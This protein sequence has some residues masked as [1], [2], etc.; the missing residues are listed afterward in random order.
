VWRHKRAA[1]HDATHAYA[2]YSMGRRTLAE[3]SHQTGL[4]LRTWQRRFDAYTPPVPVIEVSAEPVALTF[5]AT[6]FGRGYGVLIFRALGKNIHWQEIANERMADIEAGLLHLKR[7]GWLFSSITLDGRKGAISLLE[8]HFP[9]VP[10]QMCLFHQKAI[11]RRYLTNTPKTKCAKELQALMSFFLHIPEKLFLECLADLQM[12]YA[13]FLKE[14][15]DK[16]Q[17]MHRRL[18]SALRSLRTNAPYLFAYQRFPELAIPATTNSCDGS[19]AH[20]K[21]KIK[22]HRGMRHHRRAKMIRFLLSKT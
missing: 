19:F 11:I 7:Q 3:I 16:K 8:W 14:R 5:D 9:D 13:D 20:W 10:I 6:F 22:I 18:R 2:S 21:A 15:N 4:S 1:L 17:F 12:R